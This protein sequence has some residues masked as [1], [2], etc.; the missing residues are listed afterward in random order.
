MLDIRRWRIQMGLCLAY[1]PVFVCLFVCFLGSKR[2]ES[3][4]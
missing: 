2:G 3:P 1:C 4:D